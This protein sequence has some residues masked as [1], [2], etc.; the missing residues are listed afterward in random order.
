MK[1][2]HD[3]KIQQL[4]LDHADSLKKAAKHLN[5]KRKMEVEEL[6]R[7]LTRQHETHL[8]EIEEGHQK[9]VSQLQKDHE[10]SQEDAEES[11]EQALTR[12]ARVSQDHGREKGRRYALEKS[13]EELQRQLKAQKK[14]LQ[15]KYGEELDKRTRIWESEKESILATLQ[16]EFNDAFKFL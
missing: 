10:R 15:T 3:A 7:K 2:D 8:E 6:S 9:R 1:S 14:D 16:R 4:E 5:E 12:M 11:L 13:V